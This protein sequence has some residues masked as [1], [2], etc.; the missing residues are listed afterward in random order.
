MQM[1]LTQKLELAFW[2]VIIYRLSRYTI[3]RRLMNLGYRFTEQN[4]LRSFAQIT[5]LI[6]FIG[7]F[8][9][10]LTTLLFSIIL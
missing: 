4:D 3:F 7:F 10:F 6:A 5:V 8:S 1:N 2:D 9:G